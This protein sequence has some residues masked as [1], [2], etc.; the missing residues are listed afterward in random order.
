MSN[1]LLKKDKILLVLLLFLINVL[2]WVYVLSTSRVTVA[3]LGFSIVAYTFGL[4]HAFD[5]DHIAAIDNVVRKLTYEKK[6][7]WNTGFFFSAGHSTIVMIMA[8]IVV[9]AVG[10]TARLIP[11]I[12]NLGTLLGTSISALFL[13]VIAAVNIVLLTKYVRNYGNNTTR[14]EGRIGGLMSQIFG[15]FFVHI[16][17]SWKIY[18]IGVLFGLGFDTASEISLLAISAM[19]IHSMPIINVLMLPVLFALGM[20][21]I[22]TLDG[23]FMQHAY[24]YGNKEPRFRFVYTVSMTSVSIG[25]AIF[26]GVLESLQLLLGTGKYSHG[27]A[28][29][30]LSRLG[31]VIVGTFVITWILALIASKLRMRSKN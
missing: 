24:N 6:E 2:T 11:K 5:A 4:R 14:S 20:S 13:F 28:S 7:S 15:R 27:I 30:S 31:Y 19:A 18:P 23:L 12:G 22:D 25:I 9:F 3:I 16:D 26:I 21:L 10:G 29:I 1:N 8:V 17:A